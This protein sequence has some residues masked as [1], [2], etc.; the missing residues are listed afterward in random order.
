MVNPKKETFMNKKTAALAAFSIVSFFS[1]SCA[2]ADAASAEALAR[3]SGC[4]KCHAPDK[5]KDGP[6]MK[7][8]SAKV[9]KE[10]TPIQKLIDRVTKG[11]VTVKIDGKDEEHEVLKDTS[12]AAGKD[13]IEWYLSHK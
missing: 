11:G 1:S 5:K 4:L 8:I 3:K 2:L 7:E 10:G 9:A 6:S 12:P 13:V